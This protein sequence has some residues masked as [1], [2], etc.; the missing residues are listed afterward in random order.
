MKRKIEFYITVILF[1]ITHITFAQTPPIP[2]NW[3]MVFEDDFNG[4]QLDNQKWRVGGHFLGINGIAGNYPQNISVE[5]GNLK[6]K[7]EKKTFV[8]AGKTY[9]YAAGE[10]STFQKF[11]LKFGYFEARIKYDVVTGTWP[12][13]WTI[14]D[15]GYYGNEDYARES[16]LKFDLSS[17]SQPVSS[18]KLKVMVTNYS[19]QSGMA[20]VTVHPLLSNNW[21]ENSIT[22]N[23][24]PV[25]DPV[26]LEQFTGTADQN[27]TNQITQGQY[28]EVDVTDYI[29]KQI[30]L[31][32]Q[33]GFALVDI[34][35]NDRLLVFGSKE[36][37]SEPDRPRLVINNSQTI[38]PSDDAYV[39]GGANSDNNFGT[40]ASLELK[41][42]W[43]NTS[44]TYDGGM[45]LDVMESLGI[46]GNN[47]V[48]EA[49]HWDGYEADEKSEDSGK[50]NLNPA[51]DGYHIYAMNWKPGRVDFYIDNVLTWSF[52]SSRVGYEDSYVLLSHQ[53]GGWDNNGN[54]DDAHLPVNMYVDY[55]RVYKNLDI[56]DFDPQ[57]QV[58]SDFSGV[59]EEYKMYDDA[60]HGDV[61]A[62]DGIHTVDIRITPAQSGGGNWFVK[63]V[64]NNI[65]WPV[66]GDGNKPSWFVTNK[67]NQTVK[68]TFNTN[69]NNNGWIPATNIGNADDQPIA[70]EKFYLKIDGIGNEMMYDD[71]THGDISA[72]DK[73][74]TLK[75]NI[76]SAGTYNWVVT[77]N[78]TSEKHSWANNG[79]QKWAGNDKASF[80]TNS[81]NQEMYFYLNHNDGRIKSSSYTI[82]KLKTKIF[83]EGPF[84]KSTNVMDINL[85]NEIPTTSPYPEDVRS[86]NTI[87][88]NVV[89]WVLVQIRTTPNG[90]AV[91]SR[92]AFLRNDGMIVGDDG[93]TEEINLEAPANDYYIVIKHRNH[94]MVMSSYKVALS[95]N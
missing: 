12:A 80:T 61:N 2:G 86:V 75:K 90:V 30:N 6:I 5:N 50:L 69:T 35:M 31:N 92:S 9:N 41:D 71:G 34:F 91:A 67:N 39:R 76:S 88:A 29:N 20:N 95:E 56:Q 83:L 70:G 84:N 52:D 8:F 18:A 11:R 54:V 82:V 53:F 79:R 81:P 47:K 58:S 87:P 57:Y 25:F 49:V 3:N 36:S 14:P 93:I 64:N 48:Q 43:G 10:I 7:G 72:G 28:I 23:N 63:D 60:T 4:T 19:D 22:W 74:Y 17:F 13:F 42:P 85:Q 62:G 73:I 40:S 55:V 44:T 21:N 78:G 89:D 1:I 33:A 15:R 45:E 38:Y 24:K 26:W 51:S 66:E 59:W 68:F 77:R 94:L 65:L 32:Q 16:Y 27:L 46:W 37:A